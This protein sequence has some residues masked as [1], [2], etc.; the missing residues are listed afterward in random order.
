MRIL[1]GIHGIDGE[2]GSPGEFGLKGEQGDRG[3]P[4]MKQY[5]IFVFYKM[6]PDFWIL[7]YTEIF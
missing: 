2:Q 3:Y 7:L 5:Y 4:G 6:L 1:L